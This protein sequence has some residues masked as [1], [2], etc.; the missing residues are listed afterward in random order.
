MINDFIVNCGH[1][2]C[3]SIPEDVDG[4]A[5]EDDED[6]P[7]DDEGKHPVAQDSPVYV[8]RKKTVAQDFF[9]IQFRHN[10]DYE[11]P[12]FSQVL[13]IILVI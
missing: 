13:K 1:I 3:A 6:E 2:S 8:T 11:N 10:H 12:K 4:D 7:D 5:E 9:L